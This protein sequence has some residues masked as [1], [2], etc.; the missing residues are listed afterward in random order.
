M[1][2]KISCSSSNSR[3]ISDTTVLAL[4]GRSWTLL[5]ALEC[6][7]TFLD[8]LGCSWTFWG[9]VDVAV[10]DV[11]VLD[12]AVLDVAVLDVAVLEILGCSWTLLVFLDD[13][14]RF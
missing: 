8:T 5:D 7:W 11:A 4:G 6:S 13:L 10:L 1:E 12:V 2:S 9:V 3:Y 14:G